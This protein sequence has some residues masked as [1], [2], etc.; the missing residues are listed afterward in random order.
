MLHIGTFWDQQK[1]LYNRLRHTK[2][3]QI[4]YI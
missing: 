4:K 3:K 1:A 2:E